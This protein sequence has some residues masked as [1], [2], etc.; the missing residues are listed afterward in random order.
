M[1]SRLALF[2]HFSLFK[3][4]YGHQGVNMRVDN[5]HWTVAKYYYRAVMEDE[6]HASPIIFLHLARELALGRATTR[7]L[8]FLG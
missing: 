5:A 7:D 1:V 2:F 6:S 8:C 4:C 3:T